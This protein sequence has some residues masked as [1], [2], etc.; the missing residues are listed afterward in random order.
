MAELE[1]TIAEL[2]AAIDHHADGDLLADA[3]HFDDDVIP[4]MKAV[5]DVA[6]KLEGDRRRRPL[7]AADLSGDAVHQVANGG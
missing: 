7:A 4:A 3:K 6:D 2:E 5:R 1:K